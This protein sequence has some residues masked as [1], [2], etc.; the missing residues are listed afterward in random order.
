[1]LELG[2]HPESN[3]DDWSLAPRKFE[4]LFN[5]LSQI[6]Q[7]YFDLGICGFCLT[8]TGES[9]VANKR[10]VPLK[11]NLSFPRTMSAGYLGLKSQLWSI[12]TSIFKGNYLESISLGAVAA[13]VSLE[14]PGLKQSWREAK[15]LFE[16]R[17]PWKKYVVW[18]SQSIWIQ[19]EN[20]IVSFVSLSFNLTVGKKKSQLRNCLHQTGLWNISVGHFQ[21]CWLMWEGS[22]H[23]GQ[24]R[25]GKAG[26]R[27]IRN[28]TLILIILKKKIQQKEENWHPTMFDS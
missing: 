4:S 28:V 19:K 16:G 25:P 26:L 13:W 14:S 22:A 8:G 6:F 15:E 3:V 5:T 27:N 12:Q 9:A 7:W 23:C 20:I 17:E 24:R 21:D 1:M 10:P 2:R 11:R 18:Q